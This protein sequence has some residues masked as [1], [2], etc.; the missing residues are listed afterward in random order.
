MN[1]L[2]LCSNVGRWTAAI[3]CVMTLEGSALARTAPLVLI[4]ARAI[5]GPTHNERALAVPHAG[6]LG[7]RT[8][9]CHISRHPRDGG[10]A[11]RVCPVMLADA[12]APDAR[13][14]DQDE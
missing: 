14:P 7:A 2:L 5:A 13:T 4:A 9:I 6:W 3:A 11:L 1:R 12:R 10:R 8:T